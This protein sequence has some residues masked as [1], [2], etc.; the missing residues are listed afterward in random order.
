MTIEPSQRWQRGDFHISSDN[1]ELDLGGY[2]RILDLQQLGV[3]KH[4][5]NSKIINR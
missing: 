1:S 5:E 3:R 4:E 2:P